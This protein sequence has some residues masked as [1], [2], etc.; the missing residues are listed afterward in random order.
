MPGL[1]DLDRLAR[2]PKVF[3]ALGRTPHADFLEKHPAGLA[4]DVTEA[5]LRKAS[6]AD[7]N[8]PQREGGKK[9]DKEPLA[10]YNV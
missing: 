2:P 3:R 1:W 6:V 7:K 8:R 4:G 10:H 9:F 5:R